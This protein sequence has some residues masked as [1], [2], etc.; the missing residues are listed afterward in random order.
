MRIVLRDAYTD[1]PLFASDPLNDAG[2]WKELA[3][4]IYDPELHDAAAAWPSSA[5]RPASPIRGKLWLDD[6][7]SLPKFL[8]IIRATILSVRRRTIREFR[9][10]NAA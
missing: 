5:S 9:P 7:N 6:F 2:F 1:A 10:G 3:L 8:P 4:E